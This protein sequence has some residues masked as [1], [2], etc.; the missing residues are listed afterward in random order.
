M[1]NNKFY[2]A[3]PLVLVLISCQTKG[4]H[5]SPSSHE[6]A[7]VSSHQKTAT[8][9]NGASSH[10]SFVPAKNESPFVPRGLEYDSVLTTLAFGSCANQD[11]P[12]PLWKTILD[13]NPQLFVFMGD[14]IYASSPNQKPIKDQYKKMD[15][16]PEYVAMREKVPFMATWDDHDFGQND[17]GVDNPEK[18]E[19]RKQFLAYWRYVNDATERK[20]KGLYHAK[21]F[22]PSHRLVQVIMLDTRWSRSPLEK[23]SNPSR[24]FEATQDKKTTILGEEQWEWLEEE[25]REKADVRFIVS[26]I[27]VIPEDHGFEKWGNF[28]H[29]KQRLFQLIKKTNAKNVIFVSGDR[30]IG[31]ISKTNLPGYG[32]LF[33]VTASSINRPTSLEE[34]DKTY[35]FPSYNKENFGLAKIDWESSQ[36][37]FELKNLSNEVVQAVNIPVKL[38]KRKPEPI[39]KEKKKKRKK[40]K[41]RSR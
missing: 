12:Q 8:G 18:E 7:E 39:P 21:I 31:T 34:S 25:L 16:I 11:Q 14:N 35:L 17:G 29:E 13:N 9:P 36:F 23:S 19:A 33:E 10:L 26:S 38:E 41:N 24:K 4:P 40:K 32:D 22:G 2:L 37:T 1:T 6:S 3:L 20:Q 27:Q 5:A 30:H 15:K 28:P